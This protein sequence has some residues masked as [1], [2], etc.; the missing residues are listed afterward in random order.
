MNPNCGCPHLEEEHGSCEVGPYCKHKNCRCVDGTYYGEMNNPKS[1]KK[2]WAALRELAK[3]TP[4]RNSGAL[5]S[6]VKYCEA[7]PKER[8]WQALR[9]WA[10]FNFILA[11]KY[12][13]HDIQSACFGL[14]KS[15]DELKDTFYWEGKDGGCK[16]SVSHYYRS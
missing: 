15:A 9:N 13:P 6:F 3:E 14:F 5:A 2:S 11:S 1:L 4:T 16:N 12:G 8:F 10:G 7:H